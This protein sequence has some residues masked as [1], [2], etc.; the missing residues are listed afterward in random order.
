MCYVL[1]SS[2]WD[3]CPWSMATITS[4]IDKIMYIP[5]PLTLPHAI[6]GFDYFDYYV[7]LQNTA[8]MIIEVKG[9]SIGM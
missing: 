4:A 9:I 3:E 8:P 2:F 6:M 1:E 7:K 5:A